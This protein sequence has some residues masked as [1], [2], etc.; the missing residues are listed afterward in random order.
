MLRNQQD[1][2]YG[3]IVSVQLELT[4]TLFVELRVNAPA[5]S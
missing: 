3:Q 4:A 5:N 2:L 1:M